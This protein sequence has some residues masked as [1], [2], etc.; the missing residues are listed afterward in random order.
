MV[1]VLT[2]VALT[3]DVSNSPSSTRGLRDSYSYELS[4]AKDSQ[5]HVIRH[6]VV[7]VRINHILVRDT[8][9][10]NAIVE[11]T[12]CYLTHTANLNRVIRSHVPQGTDVPVVRRSTMVERP[13]IFPIQGGHSLSCIFRRICN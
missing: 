13:L 2:F 12:P 4:Y 9:L 10:A 11:K 6:R 5:R 1:L 7:T 8:V 3:A